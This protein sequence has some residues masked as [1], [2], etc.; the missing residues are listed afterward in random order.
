MGA[1]TAVS[2]TA[3]MDDL[4]LHAPPTDQRHT[5]AA[6]G[7]SSPHPSTRS[8]SSGDSALRT[9]VVDDHPAVRR[10]LVEILDAEEGIRVVGAV[11]NAREGLQEVERHRPDV[12]V[13]DYHLP[14][15]DGLRM[16]LRLQSLPKTPGTVVYSA[17]ADDALAVLGL[18]AGA[19]RLTSKAVPAP[20]LCAAVVAV[21]NGE[22]V[23]VRPST[24][25]LERQGSRLDPDDVAILG[26]L[27]H[28][29]EPAEIA[30]VLAISSEWLTARRWA[31]L[32]RLQ[33]RARG[34]H[35]AARG[36]GAE[37]AAGAARL[38]GASS[39]S[40]AA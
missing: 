36:L 1:A 6:R 25:A 40:S 3:V 39:G 29:T 20:Q 28:R 37:P 32:R 19:D 13:L 16:C 2:D 21:G 18:V 10:G 31:M 38:L 4:S 17:F 22:D 11:G 35:E 27:A 33:S 24:A 14:D 12:A 15:E 23:F 8:V 26:M 30:E 7:P 9:V 34:D 5:I